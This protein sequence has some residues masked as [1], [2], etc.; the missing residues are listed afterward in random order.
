MLDLL[1]V[2]E[3]NTIDSVVTDPPYELNFMNKGWDRSGIAFQK[4][5]WEKCYQALKPGGYL[6]AFGGSRTFHRIAVAIE[7]AG[8]EIR[9]VIM[10]VYAQGFPKALDIEK[11]LEKYLNELLKSGNMDVGDKDE[12]RT[13]QNTKHDM[14]FMW[15]GNLQKTKSFD[16]KQREVLQSSVSKQGLSLP[17]NTTSD[18]WGKEPSMEGW[19]N[20]DEKE[21]KLH[22]GSLCEMST[23]IFTDGT[24]RRLHNGTQASDGE[25]LKQTI[26]QDGSDTS[27]RPQPKQQQDREPNSIQDEWRTQEIRKVREKI[28]QFRGYKTALKPAYEP[29]IV[30]RKPLKGTV[31]QNVMQYGV[32]GINIDECRV[33]HGRDKEQTQ[34]VSN[35][36]TQVV[37]RDENNVKTYPIDLGRFPANFIHDGSDEVVKLFPNSDGAG[38][39]TPQSK[40]T[41]YGKNIS[42]GNYEYYG[43]DRNTFDSGTG[44]ASRFFKSLEYNGKDN[45]EWNKLYVNNVEK[46]SATSKVIIDYIA[47]T[48]VED[49]LK[50]LLSQSVKYVETVLDFQETDFVQEVVGIKNLAFKN[51]KSHHILEYT[52]EIENYIQTLKIVQFVENLANIDTTKIMTNLMKLFG[53][54]KVVITNN[55]NEIKKL[56]QSRL[57]YLP[58]AS[59]K[60]RDEGLSIEEK[61]PSSAEFR[62]NHMEKALNGEDGNPYGRWQPRKNIHPTVKP[63]ELMQ[64]LVRMVTPKGGTVMDCFMGSGS[65]GKATMFENRERQANYKFIGIDLD[66]DNQYCEIAN[67]RIDYA[68]NKFEYDELEI[69]EQ[70]K[71]KGQLS[72]FDFMGDD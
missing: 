60:D 52:Q 54:V 20:V 43:G 40:I 24:K 33:G 63:C 49:W 11:Q 55:I 66:L 25:T 28:E 67:A 18:V 16:K 70:D 59:K 6:L 36:E 57:A 1:E 37:G 64:Y 69:R 12:K 22:R 53:Y 72:I 19:G 42:N 14:R 4:E 56:E 50:E 51:E 41:G 9:D 5:T 10:W 58:K 61:Y 65:T 44:S 15:K 13:K 34:G 39:S 62:P 45:D 3:P 29:I 26:R 48:S 30:A 46:L 32:G 31:A 35:S 47:Q 17:I 7:D 21:R 8:F 2:I 27:H 23:R 71:E 38:G 68:L